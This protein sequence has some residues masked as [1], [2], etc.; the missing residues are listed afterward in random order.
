[1]PMGCHSSVL[2]LS[3]VFSTLTFMVSAAS[4]WGLQT[5]AVKTNCHPYGQT[6]VS[7]G[8]FGIKDILSSARERMIFHLFSPCWE[9][10]EQ[11]KP[12]RAWF[13]KAA[14]YCA[15][16]LFLSCTEL[17][18]CLY[19]KMKIVW[20]LRQTFRWGFIGWGWQTCISGEL[21]LL[22]AGTCPHC[23]SELK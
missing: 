16:S 7:S 18:L 17:A 1:M 4:T 13:P 3:C 9:C 6:S 12:T 5:S 15:I 23:S 14:L 10:F 8:F 20:R 21:G 11:T 19:F 2:L 22:R